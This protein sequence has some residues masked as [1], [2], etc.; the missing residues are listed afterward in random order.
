MASFIASMRITLSCMVQSPLKNLSLKTSTTSIGFNVNNTTKDYLWS[1]CSGAI[2]LWANCNQPKVKSSG[3]LIIIDG[4]YL[5]VIL[6]RLGF[7][8][9]RIES[10]MFLGGFISVNPSSPWLLNSSSEADSSPSPDYNSSWLPIFSNALPFEF[11]TI[12][13][14]AYFAY[15]FFSFSNK[16]SWSA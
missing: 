2:R 14:V 16:W 12:S 9:P 15:K 13:N 8:R 6:L 4:R 5:S 1:S 7:R 3:Y 11:T 10:Y